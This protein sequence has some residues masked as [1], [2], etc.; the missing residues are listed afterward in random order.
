MLD[1]G[2]NLTGY[3]T[4]RINGHEGEVIKL[5]CAEILDKNGNFYNAN[6]RSATSEIV[7]T[8]REGVN[9]YSPLYTF[10]GFRY[11]RVTGN[12]KVD[13]KSFS[14]VVVHSDIRRT[15][16]FKC[17]H[18]KLNRLYEN[19][20]W[21]QKDNFLDVPTD[22]P[23]RDER[24]GW[25]GDA[26]VFCRTAN[27]NFDCKRFFEKWLRD[28]RLAQYP[29]GG[30]PRVIPNTCDENP[31]S[32]VEKMERR[33]S[34]AC[35]D[36]ATV[37]PYEYYM[38]YGDADF[39]GEC[40]PAMKGWVD[41]IRKHSRDNLW[42]TG[43]HYGDWL[44]LDADDPTNIKGQ[45]EHPLIATAFYYYST[46]LLLKAGEILGE[47]VSEYK[48]LPELIKAAFNKTF[49]KDGRLTSDSFRTYRR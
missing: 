16:Y 34:A 30:V 15:G 23:Q 6:Y 31:D 46:T 1:F 38:A 28:L 11:L 22:C 24:L 14:A 10:F 44:A 12:V 33:H 37:C 17:G 9:E 18:A 20:I 35:G 19:V 39:L 4:F 49:V 45:T 40:F 36:A 7:Y 25:T 48:E 27:L 41:F 43:F 42:C 8:M 13:P 5:E 29:D 2:Q 32:S 26:Q 47:D 21:G 3:P